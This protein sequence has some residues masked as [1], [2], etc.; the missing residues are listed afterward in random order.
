VIFIDNSNFDEEVDF[1]LELDSSLVPI[2][3]KWTDRPSLRDARLMES[4]LE[5]HGPQTMPRGYLFYRCPHLLQLSDYSPPEAISGSLSFAS[6]LTSF[7]AA[8]AA[9]WGI[10]R[11]NQPMTIR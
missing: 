11:W 7:S 8:T 10:W 5:E 1:I 4:F 2:E 9:P 6:T 3:V